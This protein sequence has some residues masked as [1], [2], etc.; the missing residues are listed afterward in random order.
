MHEALN[1]KQLRERSKEV[2]EKVKHGEKLTVLYRSRP[3]FDIVPV[4][5][6]SVEVVPLESD[7]LCRAGPVE[8]SGSGDAAV[9]HDDLLYR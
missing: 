4:G 3:A 8:S 1:A 5:T 2:V 9:K 6:S 7:S